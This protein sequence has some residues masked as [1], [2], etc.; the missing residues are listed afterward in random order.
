MSPTAFTVVYTANYPFNFQ[1]RLFNRDIEGIASATTDTLRIRKE[2]SDNPYL[3]TVQVSNNRGCTTLS[4]EFPVY[5]NDS[6]SINVVV[7]S[8]YDSVCVGGEVTFRAHI[9]DYNSR[10]LTFQWYKIDT[11]AAGVDTLIAID[12]GREPWLTYEMT[13]TLW[14]RFALKITQTNSGCEAWGFDSVYV[15][16]RTPFEVYNVTALN[17]ATNSHQICDGGQVDVT[18]AV[19]DLYGNSV[20]S[21]LFTY[22]WFRNGFEHPF[23]SGPW[24]RESPLTVDDDT[25]R[26][27]YSTTIVLDIPG[28]RY[29]NR[30]VSD[31]ITVTRNPMVIIS[32]SPYVCQYSPVTLTAWV[33]GAVNTPAS[34][35][36]KWYLDG[37]LNQSADSYRYDYVEYGVAGPTTNWAHEYIVEVVDA[38]GCSGFSDPFH[39]VMVEA[40]ITHIVATEDTICNGGEVTLT[41]TLENYNLEYLRYQW[42]KNELTEANRILGAHEPV[43]TVMPDESTTYYVEVYSTLTNSSS[44]YAALT[45]LCTALDTFR[46]EVV[47]DPVIDSVVISD[48]SVCDGGQ[49]TIVAHATGGVPSDEYVFTWYRNNELMEGITDSVFTESPMTIDGNITKYVYSATVSQASSGCLSVRTFASDTLTVYPNPTVVIAGDPIICEDS[50]IMLSANVTNDYMNAGLTYTWLLYNDTIREASTTQDTIVDVRG[51]QDYA[52]VY[53]VVVDNPHGCRVESAP[54]YVYVNDTIVVEVTSTEDTICT[55]GVVTLTAN[56]GDYNDSDLTYRWYKGDTTAANQIWGATQSTLTTEVHE[57]TVFWVRVF[58]TP[59]ACE[60]YGFDTVFVRPDPVIDT[61]VLSIYDICDGGQVTVTA[62]AHGGVDS[63][64]FPYIFTWYR[65]NELMEG[66]TV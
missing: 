42:Y 58:Q 60:T 33:N 61:I 2:A 7:T 66:Y 31:T 52:Y 16:P 5:V 36:Y 65:N 27:I 55:D 63:T 39:V 13:D 6:S 4:D 22:E 29:S 20:D 64:E 51:P 54:Y 12:Y 9:A 57:T 32:G 48:T 26:Y 25:T 59:S 30:G 8:D 28:C 34:T 23:L 35:T 3:F 10:H 40:P 11:T 24:F 37:Q 1:W 56:L 19:R 38:N 50:V 46:V 44:P 49:V 14:N 45:D 41:A 17:V 47:N 18:V 62:H 15:W 21:T 53:T 43:Y